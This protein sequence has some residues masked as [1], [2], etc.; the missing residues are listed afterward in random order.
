[1]E[2]ERREEDDVSPEIREPVEAAREDL[3]DLERRAERVENQTDDVRDDWERK[4]RD[5]SIP[6]AQ[7]P[8]EDEETSPPQEEEAEPE[9]DR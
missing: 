8:E 6:G 2:E 9:A 5:E 7:P 4:R 3:E 1:M